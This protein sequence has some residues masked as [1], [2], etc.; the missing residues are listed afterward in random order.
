M[1]VQQEILLMTRQN[2]LDKTVRAALDADKSLSLV[3][4][5]GSLPALAG[6]L[7]HSHAGMALVD[8]DPDPAGIL[9]AMAPIIS[10]FASVRFLVVCGESRSDLI[11][12]AMRIGA[13]H[14]LVKNSLAS[15][16]VG[17]LHRVA[18]L[19]GAASRPTGELITVLSAGGGCGATT[20]AINLANE[21][22]LVRGQPSL[23]IDMDWYYGATVPYLGLEGRYGLSDI[24]THNSH[25][26]AELVRSTAVAY[27]ATM[28]VILSPVSTKFS[29]A[30]FVHWRRLIP[31]L[32]ACKAGYPF[33]VIDAPRVPAHMAAALAQA[34]KAVLIVFQLTV[35]D[36]LTVRSVRAAMLD[37]GVRPERLVPVVGRYHKRSLVSLEDAQKALGGAQLTFISND[38]RSSTEGTN[39]GKPLALAAP[40]SV[41]RQDIRRLANELA[42]QI[43]AVSP[44]GA[45]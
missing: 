32:D 30:E 21:T 14:F 19:G 33:T 3:G 42:P 15:D 12:E 23:L 36:I 18:P 29:R 28:H 39:G 34:S 43:A 2:G 20:L 45:R 35:K 26:D 25:I 22:G 17:E 38:Y 1:A 13:R 9:N 31:M 10:Q 8:I 27:S 4:E 41:L 5:C 44:E 11:L 40:S 16:L 6:L 37:R 24:L 7:E